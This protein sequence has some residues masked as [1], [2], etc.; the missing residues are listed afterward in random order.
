MI[1]KCH[2]LFE[3]RHNTRNARVTVGTIE[4]ISTNFEKKNSFCSKLIAHIRS[5]ISKECNFYSFF[6]KVYRGDGKT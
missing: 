3:A 4:I 5:L 1:P 2:K 6:N